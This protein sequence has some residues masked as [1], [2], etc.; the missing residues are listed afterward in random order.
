MEARALAAELEDAEG[1]GRIT[2]EADPATLSAK[3]ELDLLLESGDRLFIPK[4]N[5]T[6]RVNGEVLSPAALQFRE[7]KSARTYIDEA[8]GFTYHADKDRTFVL[9][10]DGSAKPLSVSSWRHSPTFIPP[11]STVVV[12]RD[13]QPFDFV[14]SFKD[15]SQIL[16]NLA[17][18][19][20][21]IDDV[22]DD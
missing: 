4:R 2:V 10:P 19:A 14:S 20:I 22:S 17:V 12:P 18:T 3:P 7:G 1:I 15:V 13:P 8:G 5:L 9:F 21:F 11:G 6:V 16:S